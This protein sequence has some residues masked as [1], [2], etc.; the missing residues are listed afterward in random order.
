MV[1]GSSLWAVA[2][3]A[4]SVPLARQQQRQ[5]QRHLKR[6]SVAVPA[7]AMLGAIAAASSGQRAALPRR[8]RVICR[9]NLAGQMPEGAKAVGDK[10]WFDVT[11]TKPLGIKLE[12]GPKGPGS[13][14]G[15]GDVMEGGSAWELRAEALAK[16]GTGQA[17]TM[18]VQEG[19]EL[20]MVD[21]QPCGGGLE[22]AVELIGNAGDSVVLKFSRPKRGNVQV[23]FPDG[24]RVTSPRQAPLR[25]LAASAGYQ[26][27]GGWLVDQAS[28]ERYDLTSQNCCASVIPSAYSTH[29][30]DGLKQGLGDFPNW[31]PLILKLEQ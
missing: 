2:A 10:T 26:W 25:D 19:D 23:V 30:E 7:G 15:I 28:G 3:H 18:W 5:Q 11:L 27:P 4:V 14:I 24:L 8:R 6:A 31:A 1:R 12:N 21:G 16:A 17:I 29:G 22:K 20:L 9:A 13:G